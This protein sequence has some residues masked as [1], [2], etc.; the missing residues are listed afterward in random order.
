MVVPTAVI[1]IFSCDQLAALAAKAIVVPL[2]NL[3]SSHR[4]ANVT[5]TPTL[6]G[7]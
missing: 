6:T 7:V 3:L 1:T 2:L 4:H 5:E